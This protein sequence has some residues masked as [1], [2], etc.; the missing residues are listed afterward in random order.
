MSNVPALTI[1][2]FKDAL[3][4]KVKKSINQE[5][6]DQ[7]NNTFSDP[8]MYEYYRD[9]LLSYGKVMAE[10]KFRIPQY[11]SAVKY[12]SFKM[13]GKTNIDSFSLT[14]PEKIQNWT[15]QGVL[16]K[17]QASY[18][19][20]Y[21]KSKLVNLL[22]EQSLVPFWVLNQDVRQQALN[23]QVELMLGARSEK[24]RSDSANSVLTHLKQPDNNKIELNVEVK[25]SGVIAELRK[26]TLALAAQQ[27]L[28]LEAGQLSVEEGAHSRIIEGEAEEVA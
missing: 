8:D 21:N 23:V 10:G 28:Q 13:M 25:D 19:T 2:Q 1:E 16:G 15:A 5:L 22:M 18:V 20:A 7:I 27:R 12:V 11:L 3:P 26:T 24:V 17:D 14:F 9:N 6:I 4:D